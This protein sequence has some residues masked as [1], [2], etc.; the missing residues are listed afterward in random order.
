MAFDILTV[1]REPYRMLSKLLIVIALIAIIYVLISS[2]IFLIRDKGKGKRTV[3]R[4]SWRVGL[5]VLLFVMIMAAMALGWL[6]PG[7]SGP[8]RYPLSEQADP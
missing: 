7:S 1:G 6:Q 4:L 2:F 3:R 8:V 5:S